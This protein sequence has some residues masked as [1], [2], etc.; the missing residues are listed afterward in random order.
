MNTEPDFS[1]SDLARRL[2]DEAVLTVL[3]DYDGTLVPIA[4]APE[5]A[6]P[7][8]DVYTLIARLAARAATHVHIVTGRPREIVDRWFGELV[9][10]LWAEHGFWHRSRPGDAWQAAAPVQ[11]H[12]ACRVDP[13]VQRFT[14]ATPGSF[15]EMKSASIAWHYRKAGDRFGPAQAHALREQLV[16]AIRD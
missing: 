8:P 9:V 3:L 12:W 1:V 7:G 4:N 2:A 13:I 6:E 15:V 16:N 10:D 14:R 11:P 5:L